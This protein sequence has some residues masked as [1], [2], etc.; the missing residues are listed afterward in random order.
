MSTAEI[1]G[2]TR[3]RYESP[4]RAEQAAQTRAAVLDTART[5]FSE[6]GW[7]ATGMRDVAGGAAVAVETVYSIF[8]SKTNLLL[9][10]LDVGVVGD[11]LPIPLSDRAE[12]A[13]L[14]RGNR[15][16]RARAA[17]R[18]V[19][20][21]NERVRGTQQALREAAAGDAELSKRLRAADER[22][23]GN[24]E[25]GARLVAGRRVSNTERD[26]LWAVVSV[27]VYELLVGRSGW[28]G[29]RYERWLAD[30]IVR[31]LR[32]GKDTT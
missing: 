21:I 30:T 11:D 17:A 12:F 13:A 24:I 31:L 9:A 18:L 15:A 6:R 26:G 22:R 5:L 1:N 29:A 2:G 8:G 19:R 23:R 14:G 32:G 10:A 16:E 27:D 28:S 3:R 20:G 25:S 7:A 4:R